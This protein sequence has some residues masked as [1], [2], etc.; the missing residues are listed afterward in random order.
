MPVSLG[1]TVLE[2]ELQL[3]A[4]LPEWL[5]LEFSDL[6]WNEVAVEPFVSWTNSRSLRAGRDPESNRTAKRS[7][8][9]QRKQNGGIT[10]CDGSRVDESVS[11]VRAIAKSAC[12]RTEQEPAD[13]R[14]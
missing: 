13:R 1:N 9:I 6:V 7:C 11:A 4:N 10:V 2:L 3:A 8:S 12:L 14:S 5:Y